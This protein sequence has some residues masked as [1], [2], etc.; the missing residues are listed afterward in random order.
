MSSVAG[1][2]PRGRNPFDESG[3]ERDPDGLASYTDRPASLVEMLS[4]SVERDASAIALVE[5]GGASVSYGELWERA[6]R[7]AGGL[8]AEGIERGD[9][10]AIR[11]HN[12]IEWVLAFFGVQMLGAVAVPVNTRFT[13]DEVSYVVKD[14]GASYVFGA[15]APLPDGEAM[16]VEDLTPDDLAA[17]FEDS[18]TNW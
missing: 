2:W 13:E 15:G 14:A 11:L 12:G 6:A 8:R 9:R 1:A 17:I 10:V 5:V 7:V 3:V 4:A 18:L 16:A